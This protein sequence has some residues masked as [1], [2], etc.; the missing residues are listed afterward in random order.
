MAFQP[1][2]FE[3]R[4]P[5]LLSY[6]SYILP[7]VTTTLQ[8]IIPRYTHII[9]STTFERTTVME[10][11]MRT[12]SLFFHATVLSFPH[13]QILLMIRGRWPVAFFF[14]R[15]YCNTTVHLTCYY[16]TPSMK[17]ETF[18]AEAPTGRLC[19]RVPF[20]R[21]GAPCFLANRIFS[22]FC[23]KTFPRF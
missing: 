19:I 6:V 1:F 17:T 11:A 16:H 20:A 10:Q 22:R 5:L 7:T 3:E 23:L 12:L 18:Y 21:K 4:S 13:C 9:L 8:P 2:C 15:F 14:L